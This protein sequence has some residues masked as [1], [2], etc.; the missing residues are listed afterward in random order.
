[1]PIMD[2][3]KTKSTVKQFTGEEIL[4]SIPAFSDPSEI[5]VDNED[6]DLL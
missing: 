4:S 3:L 5:I 1:M 6:L 2:I